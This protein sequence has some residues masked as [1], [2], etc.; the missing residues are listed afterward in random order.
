MDRAWEQSAKPHAC[1]RNENS[2]IISGAPFPSKTINPPDSYTWHLALFG[3]PPIV[4][5]IVG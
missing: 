2:T 1:A 5:E 3:T 4:W